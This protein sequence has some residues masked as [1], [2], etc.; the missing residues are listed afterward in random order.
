MSSLRSLCRD[1]FVS[2][3]LC[4]SFCYLC[5]EFVIYF[6]RC[7]FRRVSLAMSLVLQAFRYLVFALFLYLVR[8]F[9]R[10]SSMYGFARYLAMYVVLVRVCVLSSCSSC[11]V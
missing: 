2:F 7:F 9:A 1:L 6:V 8:S 10:S 4:I 11:L 5:I 3:S